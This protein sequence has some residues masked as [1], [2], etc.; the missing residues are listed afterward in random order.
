[1]R[2]SLRVLKQ[3]LTVLVFFV[4]VGSIQAQQTE[5]EI[6]EKANKLFVQEQYVE[7]TSLYSRLISLHPTDVSYN[8]KYGT[9]LL[10]NSDDQKKNALR[11]LS[12][13]TKSGKADPRAYYFR[14]R[15]FHL[16]YQFK[17]AKQMYQA[18]LKKRSLSQNR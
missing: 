12:F 11:Y 4:S 18:Y 9:C 16:N 17:N 7:A 10:F 6:K 5:E 8:Y 14:G 1:M 3:I 13:A 15:A 2:L